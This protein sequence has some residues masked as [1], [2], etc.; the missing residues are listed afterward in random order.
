MIRAQDL[1][2]KPATLAIILAVVSTLVLRC[3]P[4]IGRHRPGVVG[5]VNPWQSGMNNASNAQVI[6]VGLYTGFFML[7]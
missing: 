3:R 5:C 1:V 6:I 4:S 7:G 2:L